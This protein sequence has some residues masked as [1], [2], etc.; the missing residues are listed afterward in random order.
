M[1]LLWS[2]HASGPAAQVIGYLLD[3]VMRQ[4]IGGRTE[5]MQRDPA[6]EL[7]RGD[8]RVVAHW[9]DG[10]ETK[11]RYSCATLSLA[12]NDINIIKWTEGDPATRR[13]VDAAIE[14]W[15][16]TAYAGIAPAARPPVLVG[17]HLHTGRLEL[18]ILA[19]A[20]I[21]VGPAG[22]RLPRAYAVHPPIAASREIWEAYEDTLNAAF[23]W[24]DPRDPRHA[25]RV[26]G[27]S[28]VEKRGAMLD[29]WARDR[30][31]A[32]GLD[33]EAG[34]R[35]GA[36]DP[37][38][39]MLLAARILTR[40]GATDRAAL[41]EGLA[42][43][44]EDVGWLVDELRDDAIVLASGAAG[45]TQRLVLRG[46]L[47][48][49]RQVEPPP[50]LIATRERVLARAPAQLAEAWTERAAT[51]AASYR[52]NAMDLAPRLDPE[53]ILRG[54]R[55]SVPPVPT[56]LRRIARGLMSR[57]TALRARLAVNDALAA[58]SIQ[59]PFASARRSF[60]ALAAMPPIEFA[61]PAV[62]PIRP[63]RDSPDGNPAKT[64]SHSE[65]HDH[66]EMSP[67]P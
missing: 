1:M 29:R 45:A 8:P 24:R 67:H 41:L 38:V 44:L 25:A 61:D 35:I 49:A 62:R 64:P 12:K 11:R 53:E 17:T 16:E 19:P 34:A 47:C 55:P 66:H 18:N 37:R 48:A 22:R 2:R 63:P 23:G 28:W 27:P 14:L 60:A 59:N 7:L 4:E 65:D 15:L 42:P 32:T 39:Q 10:L 13:S 26:R 3:P 46:A 30:V 21:M 51:N 57:L 50:Y 20:C 43:V 36:E 9:I 54:P 5:V 33:G 40:S 56:L 31:G 6:P 58:W 52:L